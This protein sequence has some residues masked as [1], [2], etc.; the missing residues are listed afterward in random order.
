MTA[1]AHTP[2][3]AGR[4]RDAERG[5]PRW[6]PRLR[7]GV[8]PFA[9]GVLVTCGLVMG[10]SCGQE[11]ES[12]SSACPCDGPVV[13]PTLLAFLSKARAA[14]HEADVAVAG[15]DPARAVTA[16]E[17]L[18]QGPVPPPRDG[19][20]APEVSE[21]LADSRARLADLRSS[22]GDFD[23]ARKDVEDGLRLATTPSH[24]RG[25]LVETRGVVEERRAASLAERG[26]TAG[27]A[28]ARRAA[29]AAFQEA[30]DIQDEVIQRALGDGGAPEPAP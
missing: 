18:V 4:P 14:H 1:D 15:N 26:D 9:L 3:A 29:I 16:L 10:V 17:R 27:A 21:V 22:A 25:H 30:I 12:A 13:D 28:E 2:P 19:V 7:A 24:F 11:G 20:T 8:L 5:G 6:L 23:R